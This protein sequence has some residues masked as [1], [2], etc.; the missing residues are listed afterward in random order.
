MGKTS[1]TSLLTAASAK[2]RHGLLATLY[3]LGTKTSHSQSLL[4]FLVIRALDFIQ[5]CQFLVGSYQ[6]W[7]E[8]SV[9]LAWDGQVLIPFRILAGL[10]TLDWYLNYMNALG[11]CVVLF[12]ALAWVVAFLALTI[13]SSVSFSRGEVRV[14]WPIR[15]LSLIGTLSAQTAFIPLVETLMT[16]FNC[17]S[18]RQMGLFSWLGGDDMQCFR[19]PHLALS[20]VFGCLLVLFFGLC[21][22]FTVLQ[23]GHP[24]SPSYH[25]QRSGHVGALLCHNDGCILVSPIGDA[26][27]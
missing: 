4:W 11:Y 3:L 17:G 25:C 20:L 14:L 12:I 9:N 19:G 10:T 18:M 1:F 26:T 27:H 23:D 13:H 6:Q 15:A 8:G 21:I 2:V 5:L 16:A 22:C 24:L 7:G